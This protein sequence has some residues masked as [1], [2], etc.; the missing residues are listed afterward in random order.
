VSLLAI[1]L[2][3]IPCLT[4]VQA[5]EQQKKVAASSDE[6][7]REWEK[8]KEKDPLLKE[9]YD[10]LGFK[11]KPDI[12]W[13]KKWVGKKI[14]ASNVDEVKDLLPEIAYL[15]FKN[16][17]NVFAYV[18][19]ATY[20]WH[21]SPGFIKATKENMGKATCEEKWPYNMDNFV[22]GLPFPIP[23]ND[24]IKIAWNRD[25]GVYEGDDF[26]YRGIRF[27]VVDPKGRGRSVDADYH[28]L[29][30]AYRTTLAPT[31]ELPGNTA[32]IYMTSV[33]RVYAPFDLNGLSVLTVKYK[34]THKEE[35]LY[36]YIPTMRRVRRMSAGQRCDSLAGTDLA[37]DDSDVYSGEVRQNDYKFIGIED[38]LVWYD[39]PYPYPETADWA[40]PYVS[41]LPFQKRPMIIMEANSNIPNFCYKKRTW[42]IDPVSFRHY[43]STMYDQKGR[44]WKEQFIACTKSMKNPNN[45][46]NNPSAMTSAVDWIAQ[47]ASPWHFMPPEKGEKNGPY[48]NI[49]WDPGVF[50]PEG[51]KKMGH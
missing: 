48:L 38:K 43:N 39:V 26:A 19:P 6:W 46:M 7:F 16:W 1:F 50:T 22:A 25:R 21:P 3:L 28:R 20:N 49:G 23:G 35:D 4:I 10:I 29:R 15:V 2:L 24:S 14:D 30:W 27:E 11:P 8:Q 31:P 44:L 18:E 34:D 45:P 5:A 13:E 37:W 32:G 12:E 9:W 51:L 33:N 47:H 42:W 36:M 40:G 17:K 41:G